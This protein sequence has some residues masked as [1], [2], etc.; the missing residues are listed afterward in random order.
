MRLIKDNQAMYRVAFLG[1]GPIFTYNYTKGKDLLS[2][3]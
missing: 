2:T 3:P 1:L